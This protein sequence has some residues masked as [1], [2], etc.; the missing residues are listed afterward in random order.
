MYT[1]TK[2]L[3]IGGVVAGGLMLGAAALVIGAGLAKA[4][5]FAAYGD[6]GDHD[7]TALAE[8][9]QA[10]GWP[11]ETAAQADATAINVCALRIDGTSERTLVRIW[12]ARQVDPHLA[13][14]TIV[15]AEWHF[16]PS[17]DEPSS[18]PEWQNSAPPATPPTTEEP[19]R[20]ASTLAGASYETK[21]GGG[22]HSHGGK[23]K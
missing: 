5:G 6:R 13:M 9:M 7:P 20:V 17:M 1:R 8:E 12:E 15:G 18:D 16:C 3:G 23:H 22:G 4:D 2:R 11:T 19:S 21:K 14:A 10:A